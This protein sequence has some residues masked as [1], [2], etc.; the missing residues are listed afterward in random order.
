MKNIQ[1]TDYSRIYV[2]LLI[3]Q[4]YSVLYY[5]PGVGTIITYIFGLV[6][7]KIYFADSF[8]FT[9]FIAGSLELSLVIKF[10]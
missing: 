6:N 2:L 7:K 4:P 8:S 9:P 1:Y 5:E 3:S 10:C